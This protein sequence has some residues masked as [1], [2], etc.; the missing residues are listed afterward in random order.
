[1]QARFNAWWITFLIKIY[2]KFQVY[3][4]C[5]PKSEGPHS[6]DFQ[7]VKICQDQS[8]LF[9]AETRQEL[10]WGFGLWQEQEATA[11]L[12]APVAAV[13][14]LQ[15]GHFYLSWSS[16]KEE[17]RAAP[18]AFPL[19]ALAG[20]ELGAAGRQHWR[21]INGSVVSHSSR[22]R[23]VIIRLF[24]WRRR[25]STSLNVIKSSAVIQEFFFCLS[26]FF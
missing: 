17:Q 4:S 5:K 24:Y 19:T 11:G 1:M 8:D 14:M 22:K 18:E 12:S 7:L 2:L 13:L 3:V 20:V 21:W 26:L 25:N 9:Q 16:L 23:H 10:C 6:N 15:R